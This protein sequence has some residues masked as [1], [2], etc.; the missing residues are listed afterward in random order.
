MCEMNKKRTH[1]GGPSTLRILLLL[2]FRAR[3]PIV[4]FSNGGVLWVALSIVN[5]AK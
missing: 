5:R 4:V 3:T 1:V 2:R